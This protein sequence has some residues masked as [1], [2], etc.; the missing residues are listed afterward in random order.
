MFCRIWFSE[1]PGFQWL[2]TVFQDTIAVCLH[3]DRYSLELSHSIILKLFMYIQF[4]SIS[5]V[6]AHTKS[7]LIM[8]IVIQSMYWN[9][10]IFFVI[11]YD[12]LH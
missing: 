9:E 1:W 5:I 11:K 10:H 8:S 6:T 7:P 4:E 2:R 3:T 12:G